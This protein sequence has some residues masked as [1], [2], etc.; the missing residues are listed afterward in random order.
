MTTAEAAPGIVTLV[1]QTRIVP[2]HDT[3]FA[4]WQQRMTDTVARAGGFVDQEV[5]APTPPAQLD[6]VIVQRFRSVEDARHWLNSP[7]RLALLKEIEPLIAGVDDIHLF[8]D[9]RPAPAASTVAAVIS[10]RVTPGTE[11]QFRDWQRRIAA[12]EARFPGFQG[13]K[14]EPPIP[15]VQEDWATVVRF[16]TDEHLQAWLDSPERRRLLEEAAGFGAGFRVRTMRGGFDGWFNFGNAPGE[17]PPPAWKQ[18]MVV[19]L[20]LYPVVFLWGQFVGTPFLLN[21]G[22]PFWLALFV[23]NVVSV[24]L[25]G[26]LLMAPVNRALDWWLSPRPSAPAWTSAAGAA[27]LVALYL[28]CLAVFSRFP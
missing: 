22:V 20:V 17:Q 23:G 6:W 18:N 16:D 10:T 12:A 25:M 15:G 27:L 26:Y 7:E 21:R 13:H 24:V 14:L 3:D 8:T 1:T 5:I 28:L 19:L 2:G 11:E 4:T 9:E